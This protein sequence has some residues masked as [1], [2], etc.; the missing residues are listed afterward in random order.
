[1]LNKATPS[2]KRE[3]GRDK[4]REKEREGGGGG[5]AESTTKLCDE[6]GEKVNLRI[7]R[8]VQKLISRDGIE[9]GSLNKSQLTSEF[10]GIRINDII[11]GQLA[12]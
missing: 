2:E 4:T 1:M 8:S 11:S 7:P 10:Q 5:I 12:K 6:S 3:R 9:E